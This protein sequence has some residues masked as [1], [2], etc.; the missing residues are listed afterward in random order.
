MVKLQKLKPICK[1]N[2]LCDIIWR[3]LVVFLLH[4]NNDKIVEDMSQLKTLKRKATANTPKVRLHEVLNK[5]NKINLGCLAKFET[6]LDL[7]I[8]EILI[9][10]KVQLQNGR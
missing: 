9:H 4:N 1:S 6:E 3:W 5:N 10:P 2:L 8:E 7:Y